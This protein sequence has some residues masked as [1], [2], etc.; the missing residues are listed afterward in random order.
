MRA[1]IYCGIRPEGPLCDTERGVLAIAKFKFLF[2]CDVV[3]E[4]CFKLRSFFIIIYDNNVTS[5]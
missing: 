2:S 3:L 5:A 4:R 1:I